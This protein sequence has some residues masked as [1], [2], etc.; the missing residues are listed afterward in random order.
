MHIIVECLDLW[1]GTYDCGGGNL[2]VIDM[3]C[4]NPSELIIFCGFGGWPN[5][6][7]I[8]LISGNGDDTQAVPNCDGGFSC[9][10]NMTIEDG[11]TPCRCGGAKLQITVTNG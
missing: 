1:E 11:S 10:W 3:V 7:D 6:G 2:I 4:G 8:E 9:T 5:G